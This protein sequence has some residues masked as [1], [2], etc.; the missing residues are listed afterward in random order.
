MSLL[1]Y[2]K[3]RWTFWPT[4]QK[5]SDCQQEVDCGRHQKESQVSVQRQ[6]ETIR[7]M[8]EVGEATTFKGQTLRTYCRKG[9][10]S[11]SLDAEV[12][13]EENGFGLSPRNKATENTG[14]KHQGKVL[15]SRT[16]EDR[17]FCRHI[18]RQFY[19]PQVGCSRAV[20][21]AYLVEIL[22][23]LIPY[24]IAQV[25]LQIFFLFFTTS[26]SQR[27][28]PN[29][30]KGRLL[31]SMALCDNCTL[32]LGADWTQQTKRPPSGKVEK[33]S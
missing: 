26:L 7:A 17:D 9:R 33:Q 19:Q 16:K 20:I 2:R 21:S 11:P 18:W 13:V 4:Q 12:L 23:K 3:T 31:I 10:G 22:L 15:L 28:P 24:T 6:I 14:L 8:W 30:V 5:P 32:D 1:F 29:I 25:H 27:T